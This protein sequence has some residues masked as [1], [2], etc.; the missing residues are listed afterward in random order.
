MPTTVAK[1]QELNTV[2]K[3]A[4]VLM[5]LGPE[6]SAEVL[7]HLD[8]Q[9]AE[10]ITR[11]LANMQHVDPQ[12]RAHVIEEFKHRCLNRAPEAKPK[13]HR[14]LDIYDAQPVQEEK[15]TSRDDLL[16]QLQT[17]S[18]E[19]IVQLLQDEHPQVVA[20]VL[21]DLE[22][23]K[24]G[25][26][27][28]S[29]PADL[30]AAV[31]FRLANH[32]AALPAAAERLKQA[33]EQKAALL[34][35]MQSDIGSGARILADILRNVDRDTSRDMLEEI[36]AQDAQLGDSLRAVLFH[37][38]DLRFLDSS[39]LHQALA[40]LDRQDLQL[41]MRGAGEELQAVILENLPESESTV[42][43]LQLQRAQPVRLGEVEAAQLRIA[44]FVKDAIASG[45]I[46]SKR[47]S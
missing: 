6:K 39:A 46:D 24:A 25:A 1:T 38:E 12:T 10:S 42:L 13:A 30:R 15:N 29:L 18:I 40:A 21:S 34:K 32:E 41:A 45:R 47:E 31:A 11:E 23:E 14:L 36:C 26:V 43:R 3:V 16:V 17:A 7:R 4:A 27:L 44:Q 9:Q 2:Q 35:T 20:F 5:T 8:T 37:F 22:A 33:L 28:S 19:D